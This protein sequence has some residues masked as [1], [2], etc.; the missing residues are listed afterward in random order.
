MA[1]MLTAS[2]VKDLDE[3]QLTDELRKRQ[4]S[5]AGKR[6]TR[7][8]RLKQFLQK[9]NDEAR[10]SSVSAVDGSAARSSP[11]CSARKGTAS[12]AGS[13]SSSVTVNASA[14]GRDNKTSVSEKLY[15][16]GKCGKEVGDELCFGC[17]GCQ[18][19]MHHDCAFPGMSTDDFL[20][21]T[22][23]AHDFEV[24]CTSECKQSCVGNSGDAVTLSDKSAELV[25]TK[26][27]EKLQRSVP[28]EAE[29]KLLTAN[30]DKLSKKLDGVAMDTVHVKATLKTYASVTANGT[31]G[32]APPLGVSAHKQVR[33][34]QQ[35]ND[36]KRNIV[37]HGVPQLDNDD[38]DK[39]IQHDNKIVDAV[40]AKSTDGI[41]TAV[42]VRRL[43]KFN[44]DGSFS[45]YQDKLVVTLQTEDQRGEVLRGRSSN[46]TVRIQPA[47]QRVPQEQDAP[48]WQP[49]VPDLSV[50]VSADRT[51]AERRAAG[52][53]YRSF[54]ERTNR[55]RDARQSNEHSGNTATAPAQPAQARR[56]RHNAA[57][58]SATSS[59]Q[60]RHD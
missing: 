30:V 38:V 20:I 2:K 37:L 12:G 36:I 56:A 55:A 15:P 49:T 42:R 1:R 7:E 29:L 21:V 47:A 3:E 34:L 32:A 48:V 58:A 13:T 41:G 50:R 18:R 5:T 22:K 44:D 26:V 54:D 16:C 10:R 9:V 46:G 11:V 43:R 19:W 24:Y 25:A 6:S 45:G 28:A 8:S 60:Q 40:V 35:R 59:S 51:Y 31:S 14:S 57:T 27:T 33:E 52:E 17:D 23:Y 53:R 39:R 4:L